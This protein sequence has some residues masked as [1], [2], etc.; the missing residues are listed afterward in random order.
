MPGKTVKRWHIGGY[1]HQGKQKE[2]SQQL[3]VREVGE[4]R[5]WK[6]WDTPETQAQQWETEF[7]TWASA[8]FPRSEGI[9]CRSEDR[10]LAAG[11]PTAGLPTA[12]LPTAG[13]QTAGLT[14]IS[15]TCCRGTVYYRPIKAVNDNGNPVSNLQYYPDL[16]LSP[17]VIRPLGWQAP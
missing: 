10:G 12:G 16:S 9:L 6:E 14:F 11:L 8:L 17:P 7:C 3:L 1:C 15:G 4:R 5:D 2:D 13:L